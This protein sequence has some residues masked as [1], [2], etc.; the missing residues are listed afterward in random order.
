[1]SRSEPKQRGYEPT[2]KR[3]YT[4]GDEQLSRREFLPVLSLLAYLQEVVKFWQELREQFSS[5]SARRTYSFREDYCPQA[6][7][8]AKYYSVRYL[9]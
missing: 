6:F 1:M 2:L 7:W 5:F 3:S 9:F 4:R 8:C